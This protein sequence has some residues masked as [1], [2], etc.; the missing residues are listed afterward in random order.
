MGVGRREMT[1]LGISRSRLQGDSMRVAALLVRVF[2]V[3]IAFGAAA[4]PAPSNA[5]QLEPTPRI[6]VMPLANPTLAESLRQGLADLGYIEGRNLV[7]EWRRSAITNDKLR[8]IAEDLARSKVRVIVAVGSPQARAALQA[9]T[10]P[11]VFISGDPIGAGFASNLAH[12]DGNSTGLSLLTVEL[13]PKRLEYLQQV[14]PA[15]RRVLYLM[16]SSNPLDAEAFGE[17]QKAARALGLQLVTL[18]ARDTSELDLAVRGISR[19]TADTLLVSADL[20]LLS[21][22]AKITQAARKAKLPAMYPWREY[23]DGGALMTYGPD[24]KDAMRRLATYVD[25]ILKGAKV[26]ELALT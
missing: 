25:R 8:S 1:R 17:A 21:N 4:L 2:A 15:T 14:A 10:I 12:P 11:V 19:G 23:H 3:C 24:L 13:N 22:K 16:N 7:I 18:D 9:T 5:D 6:G 26:S 20:S